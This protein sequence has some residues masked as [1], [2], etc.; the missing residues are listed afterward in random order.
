MLWCKLKRE[1]AV[2]TVEREGGTGF[3]FLVVPYQNMWELREFF[4]NFVIVLIQNDGG[5][6]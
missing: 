6:G 5:S 2:C 3:D 4:Y 1:Q